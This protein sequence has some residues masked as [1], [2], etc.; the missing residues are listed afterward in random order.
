MLARVPF[1]F[2]LDLD[3]GAVHQ[4]VQRSV[5][6]T[7]GNLDLQRLLTTAERAEVRRS[8]IKADQSQQ[9][10]NETCCLPERHAEQ[11]LH[12]QAGLDR[13]I[14]LVGLAAT[15][16]GRRGFPD[17]G[18]I[19]P[20]RQRAAELQRLVVVRPVPGFV[21]RGCRSA[22]DL[23]LP[24]CILTMNPSRDLRNKVQPQRTR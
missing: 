11:H 12:R 17:H 14:A 1:A 9:A 22:H 2:T 24:R 15:L 20:D 3:P 21:G 18:G 4:Q 8:P 13:R 19:E 6:T 16:A 10:P 5:R 7:I 23:Q